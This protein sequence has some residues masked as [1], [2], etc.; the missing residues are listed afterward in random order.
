VIL[1]RPPLASRRNRQ[2]YQVE[3]SIPVDPS[4][5]IARV[6]F[7]RVFFV[8]RMA[9][10]MRVDLS[11][12]G[13]FVDVVLAKQVMPQMHGPVAQSRQCNAHEGKKDCRVPQLHVQELSLPL[14]L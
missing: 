2:E 6:V 3:L 10:A 13:M 9:V 4:M 11:I 1:D 12:V 7:R 8:R 14:I 5:M